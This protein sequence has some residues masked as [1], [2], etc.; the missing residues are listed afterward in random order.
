MTFRSIVSAIPFHPS[1]VKDLGVLIAKLENGHRLL[2]IAMTASILLLATNILVFITQKTDPSAVSTPAS[3]SMETNLSS[4]LAVDVS[5]RNLTSLEQYSP[6]TVAK[7]G[8][9]LEYR[10]QMTNTEN[11]T[12]TFT[13]IQDVEDILQYAHILDAS[14]GVLVG[15]NG[16]S[17]QWPS[18]QLDAEQQITRTIL[19]KVKAPLP[20]TPDNLNN[21]QLGDYVM[22]AKGTTSAANVNLPL[23]YTKRVERVARNLPSTGGK[24]LIFTLITFTLVV[25][26]YIR[27]QLLLHETKTIRRIHR[28]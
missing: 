10:L 25:Y 18:I 27:N 19:V 21:P 16:F 4:P 8:E 20:R 14:T 5:V 28:G 9:V 17:I 3:P 15:S 23:P 6:A 11:T 26:M 12:Q 22:Q 2:R 24:G 13:H 1:R 7:E